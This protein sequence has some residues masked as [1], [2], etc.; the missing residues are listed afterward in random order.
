[1]NAADRPSIRTLSA[2]RA[3]VK[4][5]IAENPSKSSLNKYQ[6]QQWRIVSRMLPSRRRS[7]AQMPTMRESTP[8]ATHDSQ[9]SDLSCRDSRLRRPP[10]TIWR[11]PVVRRQP[12]VAEKT[13][14][15]ARCARR[16]R[17]SAAWRACRPSSHRAPRA[18]DVAQG[19]AD[20]RQPRS[21]PSRAVAGDGAALPDPGAAAWRFADKT[22]RPRQSRV[23]GRT[24][25]LV[26]GRP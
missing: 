23:A 17:I 18:A 9:R 1:V 25:P 15:L 26:L 22:R 24:W 6:H 21:P 3:E 2:R 4:A 13:P 11:V 10:P 16:A 14:R 12:W 7:N 8:L 20:N 19:A 5:K